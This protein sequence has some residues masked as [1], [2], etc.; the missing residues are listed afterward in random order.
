LI[1]VGASLMHF[2]G[3]RVGAADQ[4]QIVDAIVNITGAVGGLLAVY[5]RVT[6]KLQSSPHRD[7]SMA[8]EGRTISA[9]RRFSTV[10]CLEALLLKRSKHQ[11]LQ[12]IHLPFRWLE[13]IVGP[14]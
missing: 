9:P 5:G 7:R 8:C 6:A 3:V 1:S 10:E 2:S 13:Y 11:A 14:S 12:C 4:T